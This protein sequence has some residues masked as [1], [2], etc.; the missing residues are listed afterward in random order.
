MSDRLGDKLR[1]QHILDA[2][3]AILK[4]TDNIDYQSFIFYQN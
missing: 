4:F 1:L 3:E 2:I